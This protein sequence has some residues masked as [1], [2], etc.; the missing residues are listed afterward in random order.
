MFG[1]I[2]FVIVMIIVI[3]VVR[4]VNFHSNSRKQREDEMMRVCAELQ[5]RGASCETC[6]DIRR[7]DYAHLKGECYPD[8]FTYYS[9]FR[10]CTRY[11]GPHSG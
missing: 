11:K 5:Q 7:S 2:I 6:T 10:V 1:V 9:R 8:S 4:E 3:L